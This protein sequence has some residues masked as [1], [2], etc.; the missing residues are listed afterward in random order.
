VSVQDVPL[1]L[2]RDLLRGATDVEVVDGGLSPVRLPAW[3]RAQQADRWIEFWSAHSLGVRLVMQ[4]SASRIELDVSATRMLPEGLDA[5][6]FA[7]SVVAEIDGVVVAT[8]VIDRGPLI[9]NHADRTWSMLEGPVMTLLLD[10]GPPPD[11]LS[12]QREVTIWLP[13]NAHAIVLG[14]RADAPVLPA[15][16][17]LRPRWLHHGSSISHGLEAST[18]LGPWPQRVARELG[19]NLTNLAIAGNAQL[20]PFVARTL[21]SIPTDLVSLEL[22][23]NI[24]NADSMRKRTFVPAVHGFLDLV[25]EGHPGVPILVVTPMVCPAIE[26]VPGPT[27]KDPDG[28]WRGTP[29]DIVPGDGALTLRLVRELLTSVVTRRRETDELIWCEDGLSLLG[30]SDSEF[31][32]DGLHPNQEGYD[33]IAQRFADRARGTSPTGFAFSGVLDSERGAR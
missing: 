29:R 21:A 30:E 9:V 12:S 14:M 16:P 7:A 10:I 13:H 20:D 6:L 17:D 5:P 18:P 15:Q 28:L 19:L 3:T 33:L 8:A 1:A 26:D 23:V 11:A 27:H 31:L 22:G 24:I 4:T 2:V 32:W 25:R